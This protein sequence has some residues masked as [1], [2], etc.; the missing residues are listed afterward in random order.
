ML[1]VIGTLSSPCVH[2]GHPARQRRRLSR[3]AKGTGVRQ[4]DGNKAAG[5]R[6]PGAAQAC[7][8]MYSI[9]SDRLHTHGWVDGLLASLCPWLPVYACRRLQPCCCL[10]G[11]HHD[12][13]MYLMDVLLL[14]GP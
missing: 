5:S 8:C 1:C 6:S 14:L 2:N 11:L 9:E 7:V 13:C 10:D 4:R 3:P 12:A